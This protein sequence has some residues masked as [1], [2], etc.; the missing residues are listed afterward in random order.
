MPNNTAMVAKCLAGY[1]CR[2]HGCAISPR[3][4][5]LDRLHDVVLFCPEEA[6]GLPT[7]RPPSRWKN[8]RLMAAGRDVTA[9]F[10]RG[11]ALALA[12]ARERGVK[13]FYGLRFS[14]SCDPRTG[15]TAR[16]LRRHRIGCFYG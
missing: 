4:R 16:L 3:R 1:A 7:P 11:A 9:F 6:S 10:E 13:K 14:P 15:M 8:G 2:Y 5:L 12:L